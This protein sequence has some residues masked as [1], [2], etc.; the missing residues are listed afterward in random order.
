MSDVIQAEVHADVEIAKA[1]INFKFV[2]L[3]QIL[4]FC[5]TQRFPTVIHS[6]RSDVYNISRY[7]VKKFVTHALRDATRC[8]WYFCHLAKGSKCVKVLQ[9]DKL[10]YKA[11]SAA[12]IP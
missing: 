12:I 3:A 8:P 6:F 7:L 4:L 2:D 1:A 5:T 11:T 9:Y 10:G